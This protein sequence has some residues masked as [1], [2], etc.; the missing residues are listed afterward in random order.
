MVLL[1]FNISSFLKSISLKVKRVWLHVNRPINDQRFKEIEEQKRRI[2]F[3][4]VIF[5]LDT[6]S[7]TNNDS[8][9]AE[10]INVL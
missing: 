3:Y 8:N 2:H 4:I 10:L 6:F 1:K 5:S 9:P 7:A